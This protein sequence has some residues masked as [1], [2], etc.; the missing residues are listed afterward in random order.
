MITGSLLSLAACVPVEPEIPD[1]N[2]PADPPAPDDDI[3][4]DVV[5]PDYKDY[6]RGTVDFGML[7][8][9]RPSVDAVVNALDAA[10][11][12]ISE[13]LLPYEEQ[14]AL[15]K[16]VNEPYYE[17]VSMYNLAEIY[18]RKD[19]SSTFWSEECAY[20]SMNY[21]II[22]QAVE[23]MYIAAANSPYA[24]NFEED[25]YGDGLIEDYKDKDAISDALVALYKE[26]ARLVSDF[27]SLSTSNIIITFNGETGTLDEL[28]ES[29]AEEYGQNTHEYEYLASYCEYLY[30]IAYSDKSSEIYV[31][32]LKVR[33]TIA[34]ERGV[35]SYSEIVYED[36]GYDYTKDD[37]LELYEDIGEYIYAIY[38][39]LIQELY[40]HLAENA[41]PA[42]STALLLSNLKSL[43]EKKDADLADCYRYMLQHGLYDISKP[44]ANRA[45]V[46]FTTYIETNASPYLFVTTNGSVIDYSTLAHEFGH[47]YDAFV[48]YNGSSTLEAK[49]VSSQAL[50]YLTLTLFEGNISSKTYKYMKY[51]SMYSI[52]ETLIYQS[53]YS[54]FEHM[55]YELEYE[56]IT[57]DNINALVTEACKHITGSNEVYMPGYGQSTPVFDE[58]ADVLVPHMIIQPMYVQSYVTS[59]VPALEIYFLEVETD[60]AGFAKYKEYIIAAGETEGFTD[61]LYSVGLN[62][63]FDDDV[64][65]HLAN[66]I[67]LNVVGKKYFN[68]SSLPNAA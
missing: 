34:D 15:L 49:E 58:L 19:S 7:S 48:N 64:I 23:K 41:A 54:T 37:M 62:S 68:T 14:L 36:M 8:Y 17:Y 13:N 50:E 66:N 47:F 43:Y 33:R 56:D 10:R 55:V 5:Q 9:T 4:G 6:G 27:N 30:N 2:P 1:E 60:G 65:A 20:A 31:E 38:K 24:E 18:I 12:A 57:V 63:P 52:F 28:L 42:V 25:Y 59:L 46:S 21:P 51:Y 35:S 32:L 26:E 40:T 53:I 44:T 11:N 16:A 45:N 61:L 3:P 39:Q 22:S 67:Y 29:L